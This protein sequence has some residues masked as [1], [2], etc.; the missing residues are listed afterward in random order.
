M[1]INLRSVL[2]VFFSL[3]VAVSALAQGTQAIITGVVLDNEGLAVIGATIQITFG[4]ALYGDS[5]L[6]RL[7]RAEKDRLF[8]ESGRYV[9]S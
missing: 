8:V 9:E 7:W 5:F 6:C 4:I 2:C 3:C 1:R